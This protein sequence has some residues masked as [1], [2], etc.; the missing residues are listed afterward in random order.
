MELSH[1]VIRT[2]FGLLLANLF[3]GGLY[4]FLRG[5]M[6]R[7]IYKKYWYES[8]GTINKYT[9]PARNRFATYL[10]WDYLGQSYSTGSTQFYLLGKKESRPVKIYVRDYRA[11]INTWAYNGIG[12]MILGI[13]LLSTALFGIIWLF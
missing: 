2:L 13:I 11:S 5:Y 4:A 1:W 6:T 10:V 12:L 8:T 9:L 3:I 7:M